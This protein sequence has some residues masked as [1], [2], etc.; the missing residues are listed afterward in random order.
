MFPQSASS[1]LRLF[2]YTILQT[3][4][5]HNQVTREQG[6]FS[7]RFNHP[8]FGLYFIAENIHAPTVV[9]DFPSE[10][11]FIK[12]IKKGYNY[13]GISF[14]VPNF[15]KAKRMAELIREHAPDS[16]IVIG[17]H[18]TSIPGVEDLIEH[19]HLCKG[20]G[21]K[22]LRS[23]LGEDPDRPFEHPI[24]PT[25][26]NR[27]VLGAPLK[28]DTGIIIPGVG[29][30]N[31]CR[32]C[33]TSH[34]Y[35]RQ[36]TPYFETGREIFEICQ[37]IEK[38]L[39]F[40]EFG[41][42]DENFLKQPERAYELVR[43]M[44]ENNKLYRFSIFSSAETI[45][46]M[47]VEFLTR[48]GV[49]FLWIGVESKYEVYEKNKGLDLKKM[50]R[51]LRDH[52]ITVLA[53]GI[54]FLEQ[55]TKDTIWD[56]IQFMVDMESDLVQFMQ[57]APMPGTAL[58]KDYTAK[59]I[60]KNDVPYEEWHGQHKI[61]FD[62]PHFKPEETESILR[63]AFK[64][65]YDTQGS[66]LLRMC[67]TA[68]RGYKTLKQYTDPYMMKRAEVMKKWAKFYR[69][70]I[71]VLKKC[72]HNE[73]A[74]LLT[75]EVIAKYNEEFG[76]ST[77]KDR[78]LNKVVQAY[79]YREKARV[80]IGKN[81]Y[82]PKI[83]RKKFRMSAWDLASERLKGKSFANLLN[84]DINW[85]QSPVLVTLE[86]IMDKVNAKGLARKIKGHLKK[87]GGEL[88]L[89]LDNLLSIEDG[90]LIRLLN[91]IKKY[92]GQVMVVFS[93]GAQVIREAIASLP[94]HLSLLCVESQQ[95]ALEITAIE[96]T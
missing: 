75:K 19:D 76:P 64:Y 78:I 40:T 28:Q 15:L 55:H 77:L 18:G 85:S 68:V 73:K 82:Q 47:G 80:N 93:K 86:G 91:K 26:F 94:K 92:D 36:Y 24:M 3:V 44:E 9:L 66:S 20:E 1:P 54:L 21:V 5:F 32:F 34:F 22:W 48:M 49:S 33:C 96:A 63:D 90:A 51:D 71:D 17:G 67:D 50:I 41:V 14:I 81:I 45:A 83:L 69:P 39:G 59:G 87:Q 56:D 23:L 53:S 35:D 37:K 88:V 11:Q 46:N 89:V 84:L 72:A 30:P 70:V 31:A 16:K 4:V 7:L 74:R 61:W 2:S 58:F 8:S 95:P 65:D 13:I 62:N 29:C 79:A 27:R 52:G 43:L 12:E 42:M 10:K 6:L 57:L 60:M 38:D 25:A